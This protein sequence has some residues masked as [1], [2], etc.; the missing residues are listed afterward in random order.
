MHILIILY[1]L[2]SPLDPVF[3]FAI[4]AE[5]ACFLLLPYFELQKSLIRGRKKRGNAMPSW[6]IIYIERYER[7]IWGAKFCF[8][9]KIFKRPKLFSMKSR[10][11]LILHIGFKNCNKEAWRGSLAMKRLYQKKFATVSSSLRSLSIRCS[12]LWLSGASL[13]FHLD[14]STSYWGLMAVILEAS[15][16]SSGNMILVRNLKK[17]IG[18]EGGV[19]EKS[20]C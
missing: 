5:Q 1:D 10:F 13:W 2:F 8:G 20:R 19:L 15:A 12:R 17:D 16:S 4:Y 9:L 3:D 18:Y 6:G 7:I 11:D 14:Q